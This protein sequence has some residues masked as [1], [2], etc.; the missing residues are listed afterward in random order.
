MAQPGELPKKRRRQGAERKELRQ[1]L[2]KE[3][4]DDKPGAPPTTAE[5]E[6]VIDRPGAPERERVIEEERDFDPGPPSYFQTTRANPTAFPTAGMEADAKATEKQRVGEVFRAAM[7]DMIAES[8]TGK[9]THPLE[10]R[11]SVEQRDKEMAKILSES[12]A[13]SKAKGGMISTKRYMNGGMVM[14]GRGVRD[15]KMS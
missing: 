14:P 5:R 2:I 1:S 11:P 15:T 8:R 12:K 13:T 10:S 6:R 4:R 7:L 9:T 3:F